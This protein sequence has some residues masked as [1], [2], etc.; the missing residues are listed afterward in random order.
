MSM[1]NADRQRR[2]R[3]RHGAN[4]GHPPGPPPTR[5]CG[6]EAAYRRHLRHEEATCGEC[7]AANAAA[8]RKRRHP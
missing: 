1:T 3:E 4:V 7:R 8:D 6:T 2:Y 5:P